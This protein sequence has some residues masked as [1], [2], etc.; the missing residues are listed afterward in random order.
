MPEETLK[1][2]TA[3]GL[4][5]GFVNNGSMQFL[6]L[7]FGIF[8]GR[9]LSPED[10][11]MVGMLTIFSL[12]AGSLQESGFIAALANKKEVKHE[13]YNAVFWFSTSISFCLYW[14][15]FFLAPLIA[16]FYNEP[17]LIPLARYAFLGFFISSL[18]IIPSAYLFRTLQ[19]RQRSIATILALGLSGI[20]GVTLAFNGFSYWSLATQSLV[21][22]S[23][24]TLCVW[25]VC[26]W[27]PTLQWNFRPIREMLGFSSKLLLT[28]I[29]TH[30][31]NNLFSVILG[32]FYGEKEVGQF[33][34]ANNWNYRGHSLI[35][36]MVGGVAQPLFAQ[37]NDEPERQVRAFRK[38]LRFTAFISFPAMLGLSLIAPELI[39]IAITD[40]W[41]ESAHI[42]QIL[43][44]GG[45]FIPIAGL[46]T[47]LL[48]SKGKSNV[49]L[50]NTVALGMLQLILM[51]LLHPYGIYTM[52][53]VYV[54]V[55]MLWLFVWHYFVYKEIRLNLW[56][57][58]KDIVPYA[59]I[60]LFVI[61]FTY[62]ITLKIENIY[63]SIIVKTLLAASLYTLITWLSG[64]AT[65][66]ECW[67][68]LIKKKK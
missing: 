4:F 35:S 40:K 30:I 7:L 34:Q 20:V 53:C 10:Y 47:N 46:Y 14:I 44:I 41:L 62:W 61:G 33:N 64:S 38:M 17:K 26:P 45:T 25:N 37:I 11:G 49:Y 50:G 43:A 67:G 60:A 31:N 51:L 29:F 3:R 9:I 28:N 18:G 68:Y 13:E 63:L 6:N 52:S 57:V 23:I 8:L 1:Q 48:I 16:D 66:K 36:G 12:I 21:Y 56:H 15:L 55:N 19:V 58:L 32:R 39:T 27:R 22:I 65:F 59:C 42:L 2:K 54:C 24:L 5:W